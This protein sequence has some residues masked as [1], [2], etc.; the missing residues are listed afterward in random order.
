MILVCLTE[1]YQ[2]HAH[3]GN[4]KVEKLSLTPNKELTKATVCD[5][6]AQKKS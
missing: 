5:L 4:S 6:Y 1:C 3:I 2:A